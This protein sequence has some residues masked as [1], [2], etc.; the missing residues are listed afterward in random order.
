MGRTTAVGTPLDR[1]YHF[2]YDALGRLLEVQDPLGVALTLERNDPRGLVTAI[3]RPVPGLRTAMTHDAAGHVLSMV[4]GEGATWSAAY[5]SSGRRVSRTD[6]I[7]RTWTT[8]YDARNR[9]SR[10]V[11]PTGVTADF[12]YDAVGRLVRRLYS[13]GTDVQ[14]AYD[15][16]GNLVSATGFSAAY[17][18]AN[19]MVACNGL[20]IGRDANG[21]KS[22]LTYAP[23]KT[24][25]YQHDADG[26]VVRIDDWLGGTTTFG[27]DADGRK[28]SAT[29][30]NGVVSTWAYDEDG[31]LVRVT[32]TDPNG[33]LV[34]ADVVLTLD[35]AG[36]TV[37]ADRNVPV[38]GSPPLGTTALPRDPASQ[39]SGVSIPVYD[40]LGNVV[41]EEAVAYSWDAAGRPRTFTTATTIVNSVAA[42]GLDRVVAV[43]TPQA[44]KEFVH[45]ASGAPDDGEW[46][47]Y[48]DVNPYTG[49]PMFQTGW[50]R[51]TP[52]SPPAPA[53]ERSN[54]IDQ[55][56]T[57]AGPDGAP[58][59]VVTAP[60][61]DPAEPRFFLHFDEAGNVI[62]VT[63]DAAS[64]VQATAY[65]PY[66]EVLAQTGAQLDLPYG[67]NAQG[68]AW[69]LPGLA[70]VYCVATDRTGVLPDVTRTSD[71]GSVYSASLASYLDVAAAVSLDPLAASPYAL[72]G[73]NPL[74]LR[75]PP[76]NDPSEPPPVLRDGPSGIED[77]Y[78]LRR[79][80]RSFYDLLFPVVH[81][82]KRPDWVDDLEPHV[83]GRPVG[84]SPTGFE[85]PRTLRLGAALRLALAAQPSSAREAPRKFSPYAFGFRNPFR[86]SYDD[87]GLGLDRESPGDRDD[88][89]FDALDLF[90]LSFAVDVVVEPPPDL[91]Y[92]PRGDVFDPEG[93]IP[94]A[95][96]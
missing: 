59:Y 42:D 9:V 88:E 64:V 16:R 50:R 20:Q 78:G 36:R 66:G 14:Y 51:R 18:A 39:A 13:D 76:R 80:D 82:A 61:L 7:G 21:R 30:P 22:S 45:D 44:T 10:I 90:F 1:T 71:Q 12:T 26:K 8:T 24:V 79:D 48:F 40:Q 6:P 77:V 53:V 84:S 89:D 60:G 3:E 33:V 5:D 94:E 74:A 55:R 23:G 28:T 92:L 57:V 73:G 29:L 58:L 11:L 49:R 37:A 62:V 47:D 68:G 2:D 35:G 46:Y 70:D 56:Y 34:L 15:S 75:G 67:W 91:P 69:R 86:S 25:A 93:L 87:L 85:R 19:R 95:I 96:L 38:G 32:H 4:D 54:G 43:T 27:Y 63:D 83:D 65:S 52:A 72:P 81:S 41:R 31:R 17:D